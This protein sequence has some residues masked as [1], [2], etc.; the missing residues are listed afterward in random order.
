[1]TLRHRGI[2]VRSLFAS[3]IVL[4]LIGTAVLGGAVRIPEPSRNLLGTCLLV[5]AASDALVA[6]FMRTRP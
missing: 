3:A 4:A 1:M 6:F 5:V 2:L